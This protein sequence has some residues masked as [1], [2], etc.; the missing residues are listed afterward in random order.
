M[1]QSVWWIS[2]DIMKRTKRRKQIF[3][4]APVGHGQQSGPV[5]TSCFCRAELN[6]GIKFDKSTVEARRLNQS[7]ELVSTSSAVLHDSGTAVIQ[8]SCL[9]R[10]KLNSY[11]ILM[12]FGGIAFLREVT[13]RIFLYGACAWNV[14]P[15]RNK[16]PFMKIMK[17]AKGILPV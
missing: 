7:F 14:I 3:A 12:Y 16:N 6:S 11:I 8:T 1:S 4:N 17:S 9:C 10:A 15:S 2:D 5:Q 13:R